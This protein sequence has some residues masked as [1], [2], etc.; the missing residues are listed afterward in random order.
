M[1]CEGGEERGGECA[2]RG[3]GS[4]EREEQEGEEESME[5]TDID[6]YPAACLMKKTVHIP[7]LLYTIL[8]VIMYNMIQ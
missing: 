3:E 5:V 6:D 7:G 8:I 4:G 2:E 1:E